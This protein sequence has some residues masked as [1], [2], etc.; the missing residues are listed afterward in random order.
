[1]TAPYIRKESSPFLKRVL[2]PFWVLRI[3]ILVCGIGLYGFGLAAIIAFT[4]DLQDYERQYNTSLGITAAQAVLGAVLA[5]LFICFILE[6][7]CVVK[8]GRRTLSPGFFLGIN[9]LQS[10]FVVVMFVLSMIG[11]RTPGSVGIAAA[12]L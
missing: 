8:R 7:V 2:I 11:A 1:M 4:S 10:T 9:V 5:L 6:I 3:I 12:I